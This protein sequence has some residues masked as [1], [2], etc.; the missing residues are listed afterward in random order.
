MSSHWGKKAKLFS[1]TSMLTP[2]KNPSD[3]KKDR[4]RTIVSLKK[5]EWKK[6]F[7]RT[8]D[9]RIFVAIGEGVTVQA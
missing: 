9:F 4:D 8:R 6:H 3:E 1:E 2:F 5:Y 7:I